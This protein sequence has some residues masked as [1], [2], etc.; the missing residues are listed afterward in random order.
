MEKTNFT[1]EE[2]LLLISRTI[3]E[4]KQRFKE[5]GH[6]FIFW[7]VLM[8]IVFGG[9]HILWLFNL[10]KYM[11]WTVVL[12]P[13]GGFYMIYLW[14]T[15]MR[16]RPKTIIGNILGNIGWI[17]GMNL[18]VMGVLFSNQLGEAMAP[19]YIILLSIMIMVSGLSIKSKPLTIGGALTN[20]IGLGTFLVESDYHGFS[21]M[22]AALTGFI[23]PG[24]LFNIAR[25][26]NHV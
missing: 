25:R 1:P 24:I 16:K 13:L 23:I 15:D 18:L 20:L 3:E 11:I 4:T 22:L 21:M 17:I 7:G 6:V 14:Y 26:K 9:Q 12:F 5:S 10:N 19:V 8:L 2:S